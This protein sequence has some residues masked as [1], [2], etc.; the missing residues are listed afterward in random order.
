VRAVRRAAR[1]RRRNWGD[2]RCHQP[3]PARSPWWELSQPTTILLSPWPQSRPTDLARWHSV[4]LANLPG[5]RLDLCQTRTGLSATT[6]YCD[7]SRRNQLGASKLNQDWNKITSKLKK[8]HHFGEF[9]LVNSIFCV[10]II[11]ITI[12]IMNTWIIFGFNINISQIVSK[13]FQAGL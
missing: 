11:I 1:R 2:A 10:H 8:K 12:I 4:N 3:S 5:Y 7:I 6:Y 9:S 13:W